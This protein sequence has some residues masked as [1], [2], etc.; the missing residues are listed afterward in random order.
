M[1]KQNTPTFRRENITKL[2]KNNIIFL[3]VLFIIGAIGAGL[4]KLTAPPQYTVNGIFQVNNK[5]SSINANFQPDGL[6]NGAGVVTADNTPQ[7]QII[8]VTVTSPYILN[9][10]IQQLRLT[11][12]VQPKLFPVIGKYFYYHFNSS[13][14]DSLRAKPKLFFVR[15]NKYAW[16]GERLSV[17]KFVVPEYLM[18]KPFIIRVD[19]ESTFSV[20]YRNKTIMRAVSLGVESEEKD[21][22]IKLLITKAVARNGTEFT[23]VHHSVSRIYQSLSRQLQISEMNKSQ[24]PTEHSGIIN[25]N[26]SG[27]N[28]VLLANIIN[29]QME[30]LINKSLQD[31]TD[32]LVSMHKF[33][34]ENLQ[35][36]ES[37]VTKAQSAVSAYRQQS[38]VLDLDTQT[39]LLMTNLDDINRQL[40]QNY[41]T[42]GSLESM[43]GPKHPLMQSL[44]Q[45][46]QELQYN[47]QAVLAQIQN[48]PKQE[49]RLVE[50]QNNLSIQQNLRDIL[51][52]RNQELQ[53][54]ISGQVS[55]IRILSY[56]SADGVVP[57]SSNVKLFALVGGILGLIVGIFILLGFLVLRAISNPFELE[58]LGITVEMVLLYCKF[59][60]KYNQKQL[61]IQTRDEYR[62]YSNLFRKKNKQHQQIKKMA[63][64]ILLNKNH[65]K[66][67]GVFSLY[68]KSRPA[69]VAHN[70]ARELFLSGNRILLIHALLPRETKL[71]FEELYDDVTGIL[72]GYK[73]TPIDGLTTFMLNSEFRLDVYNE[74]LEKI[75]AENSSKFDFIFI[76]DSFLMDNISRVVNFTTCTSRYLI[77]T[78]QISKN[79]IEKDLDYFKKNNIEIDGLFFIYNRQYFIH[80]LYSK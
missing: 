40:A 15:L 25:V 50:L 24:T 66:V 16:G 8:I 51:L 19:T 34:M 49:A 7:S 14:P 75:V 42:K 71:E 10:V 2:I 55:E 72:I 62:D 17:N 56:A 35:Q 53:I 70:L 11:I 30:L 63:S 32:S 45:Q 29:Q 68:T 69:M 73:F 67:I 38:N 52:K 5:Q 9:Q 44:Q 37:E 22:G 74:Y 20:I 57:A 79:L 21:M 31:K 80:D 33:I 64:Q 43:Y 6:F 65:H 60:N 54:L 58:K 48:L 23:I 13:N 41:V 28:P 26:L 47:K 77:T 61:R 12:D 76:L 36:V 3:S 39:K 59:P 4:V 46:A 27:S 1:S 18:E 78:Q